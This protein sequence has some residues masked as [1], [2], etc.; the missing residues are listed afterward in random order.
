MHRDIYFIIDAA[1][2]SDIFFIDVIVIDAKFSR[3]YMYMFSIV[4]KPT[5]IASGKSAFMTVL[6]PP[7]N[8]TYSG[9]DQYL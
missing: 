4:K 3:M 8:Q 6:T 7:E 5:R 2:R 9:I 1:T